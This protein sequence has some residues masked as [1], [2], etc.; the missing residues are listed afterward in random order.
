MHGHTHIHTHAHTFHRLCLWEQEEM[1]SFPH[2]SPWAMLV[3]Q[4]KKKKDTKLSLQPT[5][6]YAMLAPVE[7]SPL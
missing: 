7:S 3:F 5:F 1:N 2:P 4:L 6:H